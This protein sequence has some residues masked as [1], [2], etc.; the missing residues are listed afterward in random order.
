MVIGKLPIIVFAFDNKLNVNIPLY[1]LLDFWLS[2]LKFLFLSFILYIGYIRMKIY[3]NTNVIL[4]YQN[5]KSN[6]TLVVITI[7]IYGLHRTQNL[8]MFV[9]FFKNDNEK[10]TI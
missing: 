2:P 9:L 10:Q 8:V 1:V 7:T 5:Y 4:E 6:L 3:R